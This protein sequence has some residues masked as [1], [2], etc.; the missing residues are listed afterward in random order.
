M[1]GFGEQR[2]K[3]EATQFL[4]AWS[5]GDDVALEQLTPVVENEL[6]RMAHRC[7]AREKPGHLLQSAR[8]GR[9]RPTSWRWTRSLPSLRFSIPAR[10]ER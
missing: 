1:P 5:Q 10:A 6:R 3:V 9:S 4:K 2:S 7:M 8:G